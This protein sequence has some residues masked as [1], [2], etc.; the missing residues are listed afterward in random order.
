M[1]IDG[2]ASAVLTGAILIILYRFKDSLDFRIRGIF[3][4]LIFLGSFNT[5]IG[6]DLYNES[7]IKILQIL[8]AEKEE[9]GALDRTK[10]NIYMQYQKD[11]TGESLYTAPIHAGVRINYDL[12]DKRERLERRQKYLR[13]MQ[14]ASNLLG[15]FLSLKAQV[16]EEEKYLKWQWKRVEEGIEYQRDIWE[17][18]IRHKQKKAQLKAMYNYFMAIGISKKLLD[19]C[20]YQP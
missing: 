8:T 9:I 15:K 14:Y 11:L 19:K 17:K 5:G 13:N 1:L 3:L 20:Y 10:V 12:L 2:I 18:Q 6:E 7:C 16:E 4:G